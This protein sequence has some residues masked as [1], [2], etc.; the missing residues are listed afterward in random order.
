MILIVIV[1]CEIGF[2][3]L[4][5]LGLVARYPLRRRRLGLVLLALTPVVD[6]VLLAA[7]AFDLNRGAT[8]TIY[9]GLAAI[10][11]GFS[12]AYGHKMISW[13]DTRFAHRFA[14]GP[15]PTKLF[16]RDYAAESWRDVLRTAIALATAAAVLWALIAVSGDSERAASLR[17]MFGILGI[18]IAVEMIWAISYSVWPKKAPANERS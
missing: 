14:D 12:V 9:H 2:W 18:A 3:V 16:G 7:T 10:Y 11:L 13:A 1:A 15:A 17:G 4:V 6:L 5:L 8:A